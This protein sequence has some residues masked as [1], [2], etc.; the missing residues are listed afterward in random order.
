MLQFFFVFFSA[1]PFNTHPRLSCRREKHTHQLSEPVSVCVYVCVCVL[2]TVS[3]SMSVM[4]VR[5]SVFLALQ[6]SSLPL[7]SSLLVK[8]DGVAAPRGLVPTTY[9]IGDL[10][11]IVHLGVFIHHSAEIAGALL[12][13]VSWLPLRDLGFGADPELSLFFLVILFFH[14]VFVSPAKLYAVLSAI[15]AFVVVFLW[16]FSA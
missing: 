1:T 12:S 3:V 14:S 6:R 9:G 15:W 10:F 11:G 4:S 13:T 8:Q 2:P 16:T 5:V 7:A